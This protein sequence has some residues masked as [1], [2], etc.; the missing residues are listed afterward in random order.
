MP[1]SKENTVFEI[2][3]YNAV[4]GAMLALSVVVFIVL[5]RIDAPYGMT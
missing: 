4:V 2:D 5:L 1:C 3:I